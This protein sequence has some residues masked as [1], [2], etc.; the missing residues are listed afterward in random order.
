MYRSLIF[1]MIGLVG[2]LASIIALIHSLFP[3]FMPTTWL[4]NQLILPAYLFAFLFLL[5]SVLLLISGRLLFSYIY[6]HTLPADSN[7]VMN[8]IE[9]YKLIE[10][11][12]NLDICHYTA[13]TI[14]TPWRAK[15]EDQKVNLSIR[16][17]V[18]RPEI[19]S[20]K[21]SISEGCLDTIKEIAAQNKNIN[22]DVRFYNDPPL[23]R[24]Q[25]FYNQQ[26]STCIVGCYRYDKS[27]NMKFVGAEKNAMIILKQNRRR[28]GLIIKSMHSRFEYLWNHSSSLRAVI[29]DMDGVLINSMQYHFT[30]WKQAFT[31]SNVQFDEHEFRKDIYLF[32]GKKGN[33]IARELL[34]KYSGSKNPSEELINKIVERKKAVFHSKS[35]QIEPITGV[36]ELLEYLVSRKVPLAVVT[37]TTR[38]S[39][40][41]TLNRLF[42][43]TFQIIVSSSDVARGKPDPLPFLT[44]VKKL[45]IQ[46]ADQC[47]VIENAPL[48]VIS[49]RKAGIPVMCILVDSPL[50]PKDL[51]EEGALKV[52]QSHYKLLDEIKSIRFCDLK[53]NVEQ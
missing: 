27:H 26:M 15:L 4:S 20:N 28:E 9:K 42:P 24:Y 11:M 35:D 36:Y 53:R 7:A 49:A 48:G 41:E 50:L 22:I 21:H 1:Q 30:S 8:Y 43:N 2:A 5:I 31:E 32:E 38:K 52:F 51:E 17:M 6:H 12:T 3:N 47:L 16:L 14:V 25:R 13:E 33:D 23:I 34:I 45:R 40:E 18:R 19:D 39:A 29:F 10:K 46:K 44:A 37:G